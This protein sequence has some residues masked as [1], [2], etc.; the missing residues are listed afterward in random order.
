MRVREKAL[1]LSAVLGFCTSGAALAQF[2]DGFETYTL[3]G[4][5]PQGGWQ[6]WYASPPVPDNG[7]VINTSAHGGTQSLRLDLPGGTASGTDVVQVFSGYNTGKW[8]FSI[9]TFVP[10]NAGG[11]TNKDGYVLILNNYNGVPNPSPADHWSVQLRFR[12]ANLTIASSKIAVTAPLI[13]DQWVEARVV[14]DIDNDAFSEYYNGTL[15]NGNIQW[16]L[17]ASTGAGG[18]KNIACLDL[19]T[20]TIDGML[21]DDV[22]LQKGCA[23]DLDLDADT[24]QADLGILL[25]AYGTCPGQPGYN[26]FAGNLDPSDPCVGQGDLGV[27]LADYGCDIP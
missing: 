19:Y 9:W 21:L 27:F 10:S 13:V 12:L 20:D 4:L 2:S 6:L 16:T 5:V 22:N 14:I 15:L 1:V 18:Q 26:K 24:D 8:V 23:G 11:L 17:G 7:T 25:A 3:G